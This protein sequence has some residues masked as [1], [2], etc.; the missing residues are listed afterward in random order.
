[1]FPI[2]E[3]CALR[4]V[5]SEDEVDHV[6][7][8]AVLE[9]LSGVLDNGDDVGAARGHVDQVTAGTMRKLDR[10]HGAG[11]SDN[12]GNVGDGGTRGGTQVEGLGARLD[13]DR[14]QT[15][16]DTGG[17]LRSERVP[18]TVFGLGGCAILAFG[19]LDRDALLVVDALAG[20]QVG[21]GEQVFLAAADDEDAL[22]SVGFL[23]EKNNRVSFRAATYGLGEDQ[24]GRKHIQQSSSF[25]PW[26]HRRRL[27]DLHGEHRVRE[28]HR[29]L[30]RHRDHLVVISQVAL[31][32]AVNKYD[33]PLT[34]VTTTTEAA[35]AASA[36]AATASVTTTAE[37]ASTASTITTTSSRCK[38]HIEYFSK[39]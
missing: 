8:H 16:Q 21:S 33:A 39:S 32:F 38:T 20:G 22:V 2:Q 4:D 3:F 11:R 35:A 34:S 5:L 31:R 1:M 17:Q 25:R 30:C 27:H 9:G 36:T 23:E 12:V 29:V 6:D 26:G 24:Q 37:A 7:Q 19:V 28:E 15:T 14:L 18:D 10:V 13:V